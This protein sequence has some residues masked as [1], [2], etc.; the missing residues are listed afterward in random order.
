M[1]RL[2]LGLTAL[3]L[4]APVRAA[5]PPALKR[6]F[7]AV[8]VATV[9]NIDWPSKP[10]LPADQQKK[11]LLAI[12]D[13]AVELKLNAVI[14]QVRPMADALYASELEPWS[15][16]LTGQ[17]GKAPGYD[18]LAFAVT[19]A[20]KRGLELHAW[21]N[22]YRARHPS[23][24]SPAP[25][26]HL[27]RKR[28]DLAK[29]YGTHAWMNP[30]NPEVQ[31]HSLRVFLD[32]VKRYDID[33]IHIDDYFYP[34]KEKGTDGKVIPFPDD[35]TWEAYQKQG[36]KLSRDDWRRDAVNVF[37]RRM[38]EETKKAKPWVKVGISPFGIWRPGH[39][40]GIAG[41]DQYAE[42]YADAKLWF[43]EGWVD[44]FTPQL[45][46]P[47]AQEKQSFP[48][49][50]DWWAGEN[51]KKRHLW[52][53]LYTSRVT[54]AAK[55]WNAKEIAD[56]IAVTRQ[57]SDTDGAV[58]FSAKALVRNTGGIADELKQVYAE[59]ALVPASNWLS[60]GEPPAKPEAVREVTGGKAVLRVKTAPGTRFVAVR[61]QTGDRWA[62]SVSDASGAIAVPETGRIVV[63]ALDRIGRESEPVEVK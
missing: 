57:R 21:F 22:P 55:G 53:G 14:F 5:D 50:L 19:E 60:Q 16:Y 63:T 58:H 27:T 23:A 10:G 41:L 37:V 59:P 6:E 33:G 32:V 35:D 51:T 45:Y 52:P 31:E 26:D 34:Y 30:T 29:P 25:A 47:I 24:K 48:K 7:R 9:S 38:Y 11:E 17:I 3:G 62:V 12:L 8:W 36:G 18:P 1:L 4:C 40:A 2:L 15:E 28:P 49:L 54:G 46:W 42:L 13:N 61:A 39:P 56:Q 20:H 44:Y 43:N